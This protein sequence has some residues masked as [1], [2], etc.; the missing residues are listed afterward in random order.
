MRYYAKKCGYHL[1]DNGL[2]ITSIKGQA[3]AGSPIA[4]FTEKDIFAALGISYVEPWNRIGSVFP[5]IE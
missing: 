5:H 2:Q 4:C 1:S 3:K